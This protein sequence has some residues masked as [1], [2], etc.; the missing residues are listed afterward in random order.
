M[1]LNI[2][3]LQ[4]V[5]SNFNKGNTEVLQTNEEVK[6]VYN[7]LLENNFI[8]FGKN[9]KIK[10]NIRNQLAIG[11]LSVKPR[12]GFVLGEE[13]VFVK[14]TKNYFD[15][16]IVLVE[17]LPKKD[18]KNSEGVIWGV[19]QRPS[20]S[21][22]VKVLKDKQMVCINENY[23]GYKLRL[24]DELEKDQITTNQIIK[25]VIK[26]VINKKLLCHLEAIVADA[27]DPDLK[28]KMVLANYNITVDFNEKTLKEIDGV[29]EV[30]PSEI[31]GR[32]DLRN[33]LTVTID[34]A[35]AKDLDDAISLVQEEAGL[36]LTVSI[37]DVSHY[38]V[39]GTSLDDEAFE[40]ST[41][42]YFVDR[43]VPMIPKKLS[44]G[45]CS[46][47]PNVDRLTLS[48]EMLIDNHGDVIDYKIYPSVIN[49][50][51]RL[52]YDTVN[53]MIYQ[54]V[55]EAELKDVY[56]SVLA[57]NKLRKILNTKRINRGAFNLEDKD[58]KFS[59]DKDGNITDIYAFER[60]DGEKLIE[61]FMI[62]ANETVAKHIYWMELP[63]LYRVHDKPNPKKLND[64]LVMLTQLG[65][66]F[67][68]N[69]EEFH[70]SMFKAALDQ[71]QTPVNKRIVSNLIVRSLAK[72]R[73]QVKNTGHFGLASDNYTHFTSPIRRYPDL[74]VHRKLREYLF[75]SNLN[76]TQANNELL[77]QIAVH[78]S[79]KEVNAIKA[80][81]NIEDMKKAEY[82]RQFIGTIYDGHIA[83]IL[84]YGFFVEL[85][86]TVRGLIKFARI[87]EFSTMVNYTIKFND[88]KTMTIGDNIKV[89]LTDVNPEKGIVEFDII[90]YT[91]LK[92]RRI[93]KSRI[94]R[95]K[96][97]KDAKP[98]VKRNPRNKNFRNS[99]KTKPTRRAS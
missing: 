83:S 16:D 1:S 79:E 12:F 28:M 25:V 50:N 42:V 49:S 10:K 9:N 34:G 88:K 82:M 81:Q 54:G 73:Y 33:N 75:E 87:K 37:A 60:K 21:L 98:G 70:P 94:P 93:T 20:T 5:I 51:F 57:M 40:R 38:V 18:G 13:D 68:G 22:I 41:S 58:A 14:D 92:E 19:I 90:G 23:Q 26:D 32:T 95:N 72:A 2:D 56:D 55:Y 44:N 86:N 7:L 96:K 30:Q 99:K 11:R 39:P 27:S 91:M 69:A 78:T 31:K 67:K 48:C 59:V 24:I 29:D 43:V 89:K 85:D 66:K 3:L 76:T 74:I 61:E 97:P 65:I 62:L 71:I 63:F 80:E 8:T 53:E 77:N 47:H 17:S 64:V 35:D 46:L 6:V 4:T 45:I 52:T 36:R 15:G 84:E